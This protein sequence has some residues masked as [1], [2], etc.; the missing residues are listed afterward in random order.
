MP[1]ENPTSKVQPGA[2][3]PES[4]TPEEISKAREAI[5]GLRFTKETGGSENPEGPSTNFTPEEL[6]SIRFQI[7]AERDAETH[8]KFENMGT[9][10]NIDT[11]TDLGFNR[12]E[13]KSTDP[14]NP[15]EIA[16]VREKI[17]AHEEGKDKTA[18]ERQKAADDIRKLL[19]ENP[20]KKSE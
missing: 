12:R 6:Q 15:E 9:G 19:E 18:A 3:S 8:R 5:I 10:G 4:L 17:R 11:G 16:Y 1:Y 13:D 7:A 20:P 14:L 2:E